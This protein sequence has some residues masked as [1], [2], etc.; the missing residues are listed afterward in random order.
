MNISKEKIFSGC[1]ISS[2]AHAIMTNVYPDF[3]YEQSW[4]GMN[5]SMQDS[6]GLRGTITFEAD[7]CVGAI[8]NDKFD[9]DYCE[10]LQKII[11]DFPKNVVETAQKEA[12]QYL[13]LEENGVV[14][15]CITSMFWADTKAIHYSKNNIRDLKNDFI[16]FKEITLPEE[17]AIVEWKAYYDMDSDAIRLLKMIYQEKAK[18]FTTMLWLDNEQKRL[19][20]GGEIN[21]ECI[22]SLKE[23]NIGFK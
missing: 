6:A 15:P 23:L 18:N 16:L 19:I 8:R 11:K 13:L 4:D 5:F 1:L 10:R 22:E 3:S 2:I 21:D 7:Y 17:E 12:L 20:P 9:I 14:A